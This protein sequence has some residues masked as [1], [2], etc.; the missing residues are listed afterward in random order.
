MI[1]VLGIDN[2]LFAVGDLGEAERFY[3]GLLGLPTAF[4][5]REPHKVCEENGNYATES[6]LE[7]LIDENRAADVVPVRVTPGHRPLRLD[8]GRAVAR[9][10]CAGTR[11]AA[12]SR[13]PPQ[14]R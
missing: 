4:A 11:K 14:R 3:G 6:L 9:R 8:V 1:G 13:R 10:R 7:D 5:F 12:D 2:V